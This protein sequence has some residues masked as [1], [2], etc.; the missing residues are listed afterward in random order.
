M[1]AYKPA[2]SHQRLRRWEITDIYLNKAVVLGRLRMWSHSQDTKIRA[3]EPEPELGAGAPEQASFGRS[4][5]GAGA[6]FNL[7]AGAGV[8]AGAMFEDLAGAGAEPE[9]CLIAMMEPEPEPCSKICWEPE[10]SWSSAI[11]CQL[12]LGAGARREN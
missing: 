6:V 7:N 5:S 11:L 12:E 8:G 9:L 4:R 2:D 10:R 1:T 3:S